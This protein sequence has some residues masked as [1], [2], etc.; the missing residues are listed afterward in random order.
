LHPAQRQLVE[1]QFTGP[2]KVAG[3]AGTG[4]TIVALHRAVHLARRDPNARV[5]LTT[6]SKPLSHALQTRLR[7]LLKSEPRIAER[8]EVYSMEEVASRL[9]KVNIGTVQIAPESVIR[10]LIKDAAAKVHSHSFRLPFL[11]SEWTQVV[12]AWQLD[13]WESYRDVTRL[14][15]RTRLKEQQRV[16][17][18]EISEHVRT[19]LRTRGLITQSGMFNT[20]ASHYK[21]GAHSPYDYVVVDEA[22]DISIAQLRFISAMAVARPDAL[23]FAG[24]LGQRILQQPFSWKAAGVDIRGRSTTL[25]IN[26]RTSHQIRSQADRLLGRQIADV[27]G[28]IEE[29]KG[30][31]SVF[32]GPK[33]EIV[34]FATKEK[35]QEHAAAWLKKCVTDGVRKEEIAVFVRSDGE[36]TRATAAIEKAGFQA[37]VLDDQVAI[38][39]DLISAGTMH[40]AKGLEFKAVAV[41]ACDDGAIPQEHRIEGITDE[42]DLEDVYDTERQLLYVA[43]TR[44]RDRLLVTAAEP[45]SEFLDDLR[46]V[47][48]S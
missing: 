48:T 17:L 27:D 37:N 19:A 30:T 14:G 38:R 28:N 35:E 26:Y 15:R 9:F 16:V 29:R 33:P 3:S 40:L 25:R 41:M 32:D 6:F 12:D 42:S 44:A 23:F 7:V 8:I 21:N 11:F 20:L 2:A 13:T 45:P 24:D 39:V 31:V 10:D 34:V 43:C 36:I 47:G 18:W 46:S 5:L 1:K 4:K 22:Q